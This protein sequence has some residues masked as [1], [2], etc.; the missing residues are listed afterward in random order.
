MHPMSSSRSTADSSRDAAARNARNRPPVT[1]AMPMMTLA[2][3]FAFQ[4][5]WLDDPSH[6]HAMP[7]PHVVDGAEASSAHASE[8]IFF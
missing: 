4:M 3:F 2:A 6:R 7:E 5:V 8:I 1:Q